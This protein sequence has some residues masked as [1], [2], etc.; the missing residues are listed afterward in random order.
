MPYVRMETNAPLSA[1]QERELTAAVSALAASLTGKP[2]KWV[3]ARVEAGASLLYSGTDAPAAFVDFRSIGL[4]SSMCAGY[5]GALCSLLEDKAGIPA[6]RVY[7]DFRDL[8]RAMFG[9]NKATF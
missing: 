3:M 7:I 8:P 2:E 1:E 5:S 9:W 4:D 6:D